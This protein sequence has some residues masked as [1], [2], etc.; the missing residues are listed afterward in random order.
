MLVAEVAIKANINMVTGIIIAQDL[1]CPPHPIFRGLICPDP[2]L[3]YGFN[4]ECVSWG[5]TGHTDFR[6]ATNADVVGWV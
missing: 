4:M 1:T 3:R 6:G 2:H 5:H